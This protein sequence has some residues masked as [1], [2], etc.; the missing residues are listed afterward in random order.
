MRQP[1]R[2]FEPV[3][4]MRSDKEI[5]ENPHDKHTK[6]LCERGPFGDSSIGWL[7]V[8]GA[9]TYQQRPHGRRRCN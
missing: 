1:L 5:A 2:R 7:E 4:A 9:V 3:W 6:F 8:D